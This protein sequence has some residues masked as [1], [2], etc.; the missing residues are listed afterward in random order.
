MSV[1]V[2]VL[3]ETL[4][5]CRHPYLWTGI[6]HVARRSAH[7]AAV[8]ASSGCGW[9]AT[10]NDTQLDAGEFRLRSCDDD[11]DGAVSRREHAAVSS[12]IFR[13]FMS[14]AKAV[15]NTQAG[16]GSCR[17]PSRL[18]FG[19]EVGCY[20]DRWLWPYF[21]RHLRRHF[22]IHVPDDPTVSHPVPAVTGASDARN[23]RRVPYPF[24]NSGSYIGTA[25]DILRLWRASLRSQF[26][27]ISDDQRIYTRYYLNTRHKRAPAHAALDHS[28]ELLQTL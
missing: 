16:G 25:A 8:M 21:A 27:P 28:A 14:T 26:Q 24:L 12:V 3:V 17:P 23:L 4:V 13:R 6:A 19:A 15:F 9:S 22:G 7:D 2:A 1:A 18:I 20:P 5:Y 10:M 11:R